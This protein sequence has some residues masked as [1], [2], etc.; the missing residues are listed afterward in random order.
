MSAAEDF[1]DKSEAPFPG[2]QPE[3]PQ[4]ATVQRLRERH[5]PDAPSPQRSGVKW[6]SV[7]QYSSRAK[8]SAAIGGRLFQISFQS[9]LAPEKKPGKRGCVQGFSPCARRRLMRK[10]AMVSVAGVPPLEVG[11]TYS[12]ATVGE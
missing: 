7:L 9:H 3:C 11:L 5:A 10:Q 8:V 1:P 6:D 2:L 4:S 12:D